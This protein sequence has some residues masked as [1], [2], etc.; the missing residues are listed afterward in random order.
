M[1]FET[2]RE[3]EREIEDAA[4]PNA[5]SAIERPYHTIA[6]TSDAPEPAGT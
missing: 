6:A 2:A 3:R 1:R 5:L 4:G